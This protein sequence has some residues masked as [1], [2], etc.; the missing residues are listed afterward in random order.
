MDKTY[1]VKLLDFVKLADGH[2]VAQTA[3]VRYGYLRFPTNW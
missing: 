3:L 2:W 1:R